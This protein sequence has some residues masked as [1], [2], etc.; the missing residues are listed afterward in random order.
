[1]AGIVAKSCDD[2]DLASYDLIYT[3]QNAHVAF[4]R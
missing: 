3:Q 2:I 4:T 1:M